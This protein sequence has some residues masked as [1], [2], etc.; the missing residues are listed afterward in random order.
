MNAI[1]AIAA[2][3]RE[4]ADRLDEE[5]RTRGPR[6]PLHGIPV[7]VKDNFETADMQTAAGSIL[8]RGWTSG[9]DATMVKKLRAAG[10]IVLA[11]TNMHEW[12]WG[13]ETRGTLFGQTHNPYALDR[14]PGGSS[15]GTGAAV[16]A[17]FASF[18][19]GTD[20]CGSIRVPSA[21]NNLVGLRPTYG[22]TSRKGIIPMSHTQ[23]AGGPLARSVTDIAFAMDVLTGYDPADPVTKDGAGR[24]PA[25]YTTFLQ[26]QGLRGARVGILGNLL[27]R[28]PADEE[29][30]G[31]IRKAAETMRAEGATVVEVTMPALPDFV[32]VE[33]GAP[34]DLSISEFKFDL[35]DYLRDHPTAKVRTLADVLASGKLDSSI[36]P[37]LRMSEAQKQR[38]S[39]DYLRRVAQRKISG[40]ATAGAL[41][42]QRLDALLYPTLRQK[43]TK[44]GEAQHGVNCQLSAHTG[45]PAISVP[46]GFTADGVP[47]GLELIGPAWSEGSL[48][49]LAYSFEQ[50][51]RYRRPPASTPSLP[52]PSA[53]DPRHAADESRRSVR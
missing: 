10:A 14:V 8:L 5:R 7:V 12:A 1:S 34:A 29:I 46:A 50:A 26:R 31:I 27:S 36:E 19:L 45:F 47:V 41:A 30:A 13:W 42:A 17:S 43:A 3:A 52:R 38:N 4:Q 24:A 11:K 51:T 53:P 32:D 16:A 28:G 23:D 21:N 25:T 9:E 15:G 20:T 48:I 22:L 39:P 18:G 40:A 35:N 49:R 6:G 37:Y 33:D 44:L 2:D